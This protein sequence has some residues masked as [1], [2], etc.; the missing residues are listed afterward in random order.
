MHTIN[1]YNQ[2]P[3]LENFRFLNKNVHE[4]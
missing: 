3:K 4:K 2:L 1:H